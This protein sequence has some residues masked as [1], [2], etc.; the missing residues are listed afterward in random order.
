MLLALDVKDGGSSS[1]DNLSGMMSGMALESKAAN[2]FLGFSIDRKDTITD[3]IVS[4]NANG[5]PIQKLHFGD[6]TVLPGHEYEYTIRK[7]TKDLNSE[8]FVVYG[9]PITVIITTEDPTKGKHGI[10]FNRGVAGSQAYSQKFGPAKYHLVKKFGVPIWKSTINPR[11][12]GDPTKAKEALAWLSRGLEEALVQFIAQ[13]SGKK[14]RLLATV[15]EFTHPETLQAFAEAVERGV[16]VKIIRHCKGTYRTKVKRNDIV[17]DDSGKIEKEWISDSTTDSA[18]KAIDSVGFSSLETAHTW[19]HDT[20]IERK[21]SAGIMHNKFIILV[22]N[23]KPIQVVSASDAHF[24]LSFTCHAFPTQCVS[25]FYSLS[26]RA[27]LILPMEECTASQM[28]V[29]L[30]EMKMFLANTLSIGI[31]CHKICQVENIPARRLMMTLMNQWM[32]GMNA[33][34]LI[35]KAQLQHHL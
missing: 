28:W 31:T 19:Q 12:I 18:R 1:S 20:F 16:D 26:G 3:E 27:P 14:Y 7:M 33:S 13:A 23:G 24:V 6:Y 30:L 11:S 2:N 29:I 5:K 32:N 22:E 17:K 9:T 34:S 8:Q 35:S 15:Y 25:S 10:Y 21:H 4:L